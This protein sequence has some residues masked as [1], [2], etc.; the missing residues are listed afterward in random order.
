MY[1]NHVY[2]LL[3]LVSMQ[4]DQVQRVNPISC[5]VG[6]WFHY[7]CKNITVHREADEQPSVYDP[8]TGGRQQEYADWTWIRSGYIL[9]WAENTDRRPQVT[10]ICFGASLSLE[11]RFRRL[12]SS[13]LCRSVTDDPYSL[14]AIVLDDL[15]LQMDN[16]VWGISDVFGSIELVPPKTLDS[17]EKEAY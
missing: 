1:V 14:F 7:L 12:P 16:T 15:S 4:L 2:A 11:Q 10:F 3:I 13:P 6:S 17:I 9:R 5:K 8:R